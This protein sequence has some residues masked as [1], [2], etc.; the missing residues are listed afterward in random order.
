MH[1]PLYLS[2]DTLNKAKRPWSNVCWIGQETGTVYS[3]TNGYVNQVQLQ[4]SSS[5][6]ISKL[7]KL[8]KNVSVIN[9]TF[10]GTIVYGVL[11]SGD[12]F[13]WDQKTN[14]VNYVRGLP[15]LSSH[16]SLTNVDD[17]VGPF[18]GILDKLKQL[19]QEGHEGVELKESGEQGSHCEVPLHQRPK[20]FASDD[21]SKV[22]VVVGASQIYVWVKDITQHNEHQE[23]LSGVW[24]VAAC[25]SDVFLP[26]QSSKETEIS[27]CFCNE[28]PGGQ[29][30]LITF[31]FFD[32]SSLLNTTLSL[33]WGTS[34]CRILS[35][36]WY[37]VHTAFKCMGIREEEI[38]QKKG[39][40][41]SR[42]TNNQSFM[43]I[44]LNSPVRFNSRLVY[45]HPL[46][47]T[48][49]TESIERSNSNFRL[50][51]S[52]N[53]ERHWVADMAWSRDNS[54]V[55]GC[56]KTGAIF[57]ATRMGPIVKISC[58][59][60]NLVLQPSSLLDLHPHSHRER[61]MHVEDKKA[62][63]YSYCEEG[64][65]VNF[66]P[67]CNKF[68]FSSG[69]RISVLSLP[70]NCSQDAEVVEQLIQSA[71]HALHSLRNSSVTHD[72]AYIRSSTWR[73]AQSLPNLYQS[74]EN[75]AK[76]KNSEMKL[77]AKEETKESQNKV[78][79]LPDEEE[80]LIEDIIKHL[81]GAWTFIL[82]HG[83]P[84]TQEWQMR[85][86][87]VSKI[88]V[89][90][91][92]IML[93][94]TMDDDRP[95]HQAQIVHMLHI[96]HR[97]VSLL[98]VW[99]RS[100]HMVKATV[101]LGHKIIHAILKYEKFGSEKYMIDTML[102][103]TQTVSS[104][105]KQLVMVY[106]LQPVMDTRCDFYG[107]SHGAA[108]CT[109]TN[110]KVLA[111]ST[112]EDSY[113]PI[114][115]HRFKTIWKCL[116]SN[117]KKIYVRIQGKYDK[118]SYQKCVVVIN[119]VQRSLQELDCDISFPKLN[120]KQGNSLS[121]NGLYYSAIGVWKNDVNNYIAQGICKKNLSRRLHSILYAYIFLKDYSGLAL[122][123]KW[124]SSLITYDS[125]QNYIS[126][127]HASHSSSKKSLKN[128]RALSSEPRQ[129]SSLGVENGAETPH[130]K[131]KNPTKLHEAKGEMKNIQN[132]SYRNVIHAVRILI[133]SFGRILARLFMKQDVFVPLPHRPH[134]ITPLWLDDT[135]AEDSGMVLCN[136]SYLKG[137]IQGNHWSPEIAAQALCFSGNWYDLVVFAQEL[138]DKRIS[139]LSSIVASKIETSR[140]TLPPS[141]S[142]EAIIKE[143]MLELWC[144]R[145][146]D[147]SLFQCHQ[148][149]MK[150]A[151][152]AQIEILPDILATC[153][154]NIR[155][156]MQELPLIVPDE[157]Y[158]PAPPV[159]C[160]QLLPNENSKEGNG[161]FGKNEV[162]S[163]KILARWVRLFA[164]VIS[165]S[166]IA[167][168]LISDWCG[169]FDCD[170][171]QK[172]DVYLQEISKLSDTLMARKGLVPQ[173]PEWTSIFQSWQEL[174][175]HLWLLH[176]RDKLSLQLRKFSEFIPFLSKYE[177]TKQ[178]AE[179]YKL[180][181][182]HF[183]ET[184]EMQTING[185]GSSN[186]SEGLVTPT[187]KTAS[188]EIYAKNS[189]SVTADGKEFLPGK[190]CVALGGTDLGDSETKTVKDSWTETILAAEKTEVQTQTQPK[191]TVDAS[192]T[193]CVSPPPT[194]SS[195]V[196]HA[197]L[198]FNHAGLIVDPY[199]QA[200]FPES[201]RGSVAHV[202]DIPQDVVL[203]QLRAIGNELNRTIPSVPPNDPSEHA[204]SSVYQ[205]YDTE[206]SVLQ[207]HLKEKLSEKKEGET[208]QD[209]VIEGKNR[210]LGHES[211]SSSPLE[212]GTPKSAEIGNK[213]STSSV[214]PLM[215][216]ESP[217]RSDQV[218]QE[219]DKNTYWTGDFTM[220]NLTQ[221]FI[222]G[223]LTFERF[224]ELSN[225]A[226]ET[227][228]L[229]NK[230]REAKEGELHIREIEE[231]EK[232]AK[233]A[234]VGL[235]A[236]K[237]LLSRLDIV[238]QESQRMEKEKSLE[239][240]VGSYSSRTA[241]YTRSRKPK[242][243][244][245]QEWQKVQS[246]FHST[247]NADSLL[248]FIESVN[249][250]DISDEMID[251]IMHYT[252]IAEGIHE[253]KDHSAA[254][255]KEP[256]SVHAK[257]III[258]RNR[259]LRNDS[260][261]ADHGTS[262]YS[263]DLVDE[264]PSLAQQMQDLPYSPNLHIDLRSLRSE[265]SSTFANM[266]NLPFSAQSNSSSIIEWEKQRKRTEI[267]KWMKE[268][269]KERIKKSSDL[270]EK[271]S[272]LQLFGQKGSNL[273]SGP[274]CGITGKEIRDSSREKEEKRRQLRRSLEKKLEKDMNELLDDHSQQAS[275]HRD[276]LHSSH[277]SLKIIPP[278]KLSP[279][280]VTY[281]SRTPKKQVCQDS[282]TYM[283]PKSFN[284]TFT[285][286]QE[287]LASF[288]ETFTIAKKNKPNF[289]ETFTIAKKNQ[290]SFND[291]FTI[292]K[293]NQPSFNETFTIAKKNQPSFNKTYTATTKHIPQG[294]HL[295]RD[296]STTLRSGF[297]KPDDIGFSTFSQGNRSQ[298]G[299]RDRLPLNQ[300]N[301]VQ[302]GNENIEVE[303]NKLAECI[304]SVDEN[305]LS[306]AKRPP[307]QTKSVT[308]FEARPKSES[309]TKKVLVHQRASSVSLPLDRISEVDSDTFSSYSAGGEER[310]G[311]GSSS[312]I[313]WNVPPE[314]KKVLYN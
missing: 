12:I 162:S 307:V 144:T 243:S 224:C 186:N 154:L 31:S 14:R 73:L 261:F 66:H 63:K 52:E 220:E 280:P 241:T 221:A 2:C 82:T 91:I 290:P 303:L 206:N 215:G 22:I 33:R 92:S 289:N 297:S 75:M 204:S 164:V 110:V 119:L 185:S 146:L 189:A 13:F 139:L 201:F 124:M 272:G 300:K 191:T 247:Q 248:Q 188:C 214:E 269:R 190:L 4:T 197:T 266:P 32:A 57:L 284:E 183:Q 39:S 136:A 286:L 72:Y 275:S 78:K 97:F 60:E 53:G 229:L 21:C 285:V 126:S 7:N 249:P 173:G 238:I 148:D 245:K 114:I 222:K 88:L 65:S 155:N 198:S 96:F 219:G 262:L 176:C 278:R 187:G 233:A 71:L 310:S 108:S 311:N 298:Y 99:P 161:D 47:E 43:C 25:P 153:L 218:S 140:V 225:N 271:K 80:W 235:Q 102:V 228:D 244:V 202:V 251:I 192:V 277:S 276:L 270:Q 193:A 184:K 11:L 194:S 282:C 1:I 304:Q 217:G 168:H 230:E 62:N 15:E 268:K 239:K 231:L 295:G 178:M 3:F 308:G 283:A 177:A 252:E 34:N 232:E 211:T 236:S 30:C 131:P 85:I 6:G 147:V 288:N 237:K 55:A 205:G 210:N 133:G 263:P 115:T 9:T 104:V 313:S 130:K 10:Q 145:E 240:C 279:K 23:F 293:K 129:S 212:T 40:L 301:E 64:F 174:L 138:G 306:K 135:R 132:K 54:Y 165:S 101:S 127:S 121:I 152:I 19:H 41:I 42:Y 158:L 46:S 100:L 159:F 128:E 314:V 77:W 58:T 296:R 203:K 87:R 157:I 51:Q 76:I 264:N 38:I 17:Y 254:K 195:A 68:L 36:S 273:E 18:H 111:V 207:S 90:F 26:S 242:A 196:P 199:S 50:K 84:H 28:A 27:S 86:K 125:V 274:K 150:V 294:H 74:C 106:D 250:E 305:R 292:A 137:A 118:N 107:V 246:E 216:E 160:P 234:V 93:Q 29:Q 258:P 166:G 291:T 259:E 253:A 267:R 180:Q 59:G 175:Y 109:V 170:H 20:I 312:D 103:L 256:K 299:K 181:R 69:H 142:P 281:R 167:Q 35:A 134:D 255:E 105:E 208:L 171:D 182:Q 113:I 302:A 122:F 117:I 37:T 16:S 287:N 8:A 70:E 79:V 44:A 24:S 172:S 123:I 223:K 61:K 45:L 89:N 156:M 209:F 141:L 56:L 98:C 67:Y 265:S 169:L 143:L 260:H 49:A 116:Y 95:V 309:I 257:Q 94:T 163:R 151:A 200:S 81:L 149:L 48:I 120:V 83:N 179:L 213:E 227:D 226:V 5:H 112:K